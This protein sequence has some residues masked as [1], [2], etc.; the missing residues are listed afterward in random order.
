MFLRTLPLTFVLLATLGCPPAQQGG[1]SGGSAAPTAA[2]REEAKTVFAQRCTPC[3]GPKGAGD[4]PAS[5][6]LNPKPR[7][8]SGGPW[9][10]SVDDDYIEK[11]LK[12]GGAA[13]GKS[14]AMPGNPDLAGKPGVLAALR[15]HIRGL[16]AP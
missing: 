6:G 9:Q 12:S 8:L 10:D 5:A 4:G 1:S 2:E 3:H 11:I 15:E 7:D 14:P 16:R 13:V